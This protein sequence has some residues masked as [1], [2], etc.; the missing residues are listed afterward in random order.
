[1][2]H[3]NRKRKL[4]LYVCLCTCVC[5]CVFVYVCL[6]TCVCIHASGGYRET[7]RGGWRE[8]RGKEMRKE[9]TLCCLY[10]HEEVGNRIIMG[11]RTHLKLHDFVCI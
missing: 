8:T 3:S 4:V 5:V 2:I 1:M 10:T 9:H 6:C 11:T 7:E